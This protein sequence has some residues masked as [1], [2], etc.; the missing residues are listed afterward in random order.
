MEGGT[1]YIAGSSMQSSIRVELWICVDSNAY[2]RDIVE[3]G[4]MVGDIILTCVCS[5]G[6]VGFQLRS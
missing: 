5:F 3:S 4:Y 1:E 2:L 6:S